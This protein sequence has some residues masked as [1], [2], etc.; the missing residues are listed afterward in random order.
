M[1]SVLITKA[2]NFAGQ[3][4][5]ALSRLQFCVELHV[6][7]RGL[8]ELAIAIQHGVYVEP[9]IRI[10]VIA[11][12]ESVTTGHCPLQTSF[13]ARVVIVVLVVTAG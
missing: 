7:S 8:V 12:S 6:L 9:M 11:H 4:V 1:R 13:L 10:P 3:L 5:V 2:V